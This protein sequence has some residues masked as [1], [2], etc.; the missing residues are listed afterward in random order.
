MNITPL[1]WY[2]DSEIPADVCDAIIAAGKKLE[3]GP[4]SVGDG[5]AG[6]VDLEKRNSETGFFNNNGWVAG[7]CSTYCRQA[8]HASGWNYVIDNQ[9]HVQFTTYKP[10]GFYDFH[11]DSSVCAD[12][13][14][15]LSLVIS[16]TDPDTYTGGEFEFEDGTKPSL[17][18]RGSIIVFPS[19]ISHRVSPVITGVRYSLVNWFAGPAFR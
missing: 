10:G 8:N 1:Y 11:E 19:I 7:I 13:M 2:W 14:R 17:S 4:A 6:V 16:I 12:G 3:T 15:K 5:G 9:Q 18:K